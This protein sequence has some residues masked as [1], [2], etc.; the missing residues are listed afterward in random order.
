MKISHS[1]NVVQ[2]PTVPKVLPSV[3]TMK[4]ET[5]QEK[6]KRLWSSK[7]EV[8]YNLYLQTYASISTIFVC[9]RHSQEVNG[10]VP[11]LEMGEMKHK[12][13]FVV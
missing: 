10:K 3:N 5:I 6:R 12:Q 11:L 7:K 1:I 2:L 8:L 4:F 13:S 9:R